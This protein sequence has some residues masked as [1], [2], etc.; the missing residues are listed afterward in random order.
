MTH[1][2]VMITVVYDGGGEPSNSVPVPVYMSGPVPVS[3]SAGS[4][5]TS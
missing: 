4:G 5:E 2:Q 3:V 1:Q